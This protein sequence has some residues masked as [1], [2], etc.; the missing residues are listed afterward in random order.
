MIQHR[1]FWIYHFRT[2]R[3]LTL[4]CQGNEASP[5]RTQVLV[6]AGLLFNASACHASTEDLHIYPT[7]RGCMQTELN[8]PH[9][10]L[11]D[12]VPIISQHGSHQLQEPKTQTLQALDNIQS[13]LKTPLHSIEVDSFLHM[14]QTSGKS[15]PQIRY[16]VIRIIVFSTTITLR[17]TAM[18]HRQNT[19]HCMF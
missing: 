13:H 3:Q 8:T 5:R 15:Q 17:Q 4:R 7:L 18:C 14:H 2:P 11:I 9:I 10:F 1:N 12:K 16:F 6:N 19:R